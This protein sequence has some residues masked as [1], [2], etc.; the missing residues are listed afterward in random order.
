MTIDDLQFLINK[1]AEIYANLIEECVY[2]QMAFILFK[3]FEGAMEACKNFG[4]YILR[5]YS[6]GFIYLFIAFFFHSINIS[7]IHS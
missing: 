2:E 1:E 3:N 5:M 4:Y 6:A 7:T